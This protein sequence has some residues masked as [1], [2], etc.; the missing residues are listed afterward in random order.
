LISIDQVAS[1]SGAMTPRFIFKGTVNNAIYV[2]DSV[3]F[4]NNVNGSSL[5]SVSTDDG[6]QFFVSVGTA[7]VVS[8]MFRNLD[9]LLTIRSA[10][11]EIRFGADDAGLA[12]EFDRG[13]IFRVPFTVWDING[14]PNDPS[15]DEQMLVRSLNYYN[16]GDFHWG[17]HEEN[18][19]PWTENPAHQSDWIYFN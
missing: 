2:Q 1:S 5:S 10:M 11:Y 7:P 15:D 12:F 6:G 8:R 17:I 4:T 18:I 3:T 14:T 13:L 16:A 9:R 19:S